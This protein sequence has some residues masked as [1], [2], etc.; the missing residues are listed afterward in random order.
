MVVR[1]FLPPPLCRLQIEPIGFLCGGIG[2][3]PQ[4]T[5]RRQQLAYQVPDENCQRHLI[6]G[7]CRKG[8]QHQYLTKRSARAR[9]TMF[10]CTTRDIVTQMSHSW[11]LLLYCC[12]RWCYL[13]FGTHC[14]LAQKMLFVGKVVRVLHKASLQGAFTQQ[15]APFARW[16]R[17][18][19]ESGVRVRKPTAG[20]AP[21]CVG[22]PLTQIHTI[23]LYT[24]CRQQCSLRCASAVLVFPRLPRLSSNFLRGQTPSTCVLYPKP[25]YSWL[26]GLFALPSPDRDGLLVL[27]LDAVTNPDVWPT[28]VF[29]H[30]QLA[31]ATIYDA[32]NCSINY[33]P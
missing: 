6:G 17:E 27:T 28:L 15:R 19:R 25:P 1:R 9:S 23:V 21:L 7:R 31:T 29:R 14:R 12:R 4:L 16:P 18:S 33:K 3:A 8:R 2:F 22:P 26:L 20:S 32:K 11:R 5:Y 30:V 13:L 10:I 24:L